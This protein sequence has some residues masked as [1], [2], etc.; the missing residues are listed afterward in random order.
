VI[1]CIFSFWLTPSVSIKGATLQ[2]YSHIRNI[3]YLTLIQKDKQSSNMSHIIDKIFGKGDSESHS[4]SSHTKTETNSSNGQ[5]M[6]GRTV[7]H[8]DVNVKSTISSDATSTVSMANQNKLNNLVSKLGS[9]YKQVDD[10]AKKQTEKINDE[11]QREMDQVVTRTR[12]QQDELLRKANEHTAQIDVEYRAQ[13]QK[14]VE[15]ID[16]AKAKR[17]A[18]IEKE[19]NDQQAT[20]LQAA[21]DEIDL[22]NQ[23]AANLKIGALQQAH[24]R[25]ATDANEITAQASHLG[26]AATLHHSTGTTKI[27]TEVSAAATTK[28]IHEVDSSAKTRSGNNTIE[29]SNYQ[30]RDYKK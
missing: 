27:K 26:Q 20:I 25:A 4:H 18:T 23:K 8:G 2:R 3:I 22:L 16:G 15:E 21:R 30:S 6:E 7:Q 10:Y 13:L 17:I 9:T 12:L 19:L 24:A 29:T 11:T 1:E 5:V 28:D 14:M